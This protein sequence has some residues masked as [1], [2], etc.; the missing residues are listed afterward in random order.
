M[1]LI[2]REWTEEELKMAQREL[3]WAVKKRD[4]KLKISNLQKEL[5]RRKLQIE[6]NQRNKQFREDHPSWDE[7]EGEINDD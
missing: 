1:G 4:R 5:E 6:I 2:D 3:D 7:P